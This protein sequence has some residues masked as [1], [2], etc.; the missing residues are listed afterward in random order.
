MQRSRLILQNAASKAAAAKAAGESLAAVRKLQ[1]HKKISLDEKIA[2]Q[3][4]STRRSPPFY[5]PLYHHLDPSLLKPREPGTFSYL[6]HNLQS[7]LSGF[8]SICTSQQSRDE[9]LHLTARNND[10]KINNNHNGDGE[11]NAGI[12]NTF[13]LNQSDMGFMKVMTLY[14]DL[15]SPLYD[16]AN[17]DT[18]T[19]VRQFLDGCS[20]ALEQFHTIQADYLKNLEATLN[21]VDNSENN[22][23]EHNNESNTEEEEKAETGKQ[24]QCKFFD[25]V[26]NDPESTES[27]LASMLSPEGLDRIFFDTA[28]YSFA[29][30]MSGQ[31]MVEGADSTARNHTV[32]AELSSDPKVMHACLLSA[33]VEEIE[34]SVGNQDKTNGEDNDDDH[35]APLEDE[36]LQPFA[37]RKSQT[38]LQLEVLYDLEFL[39]NTDGTR[40]TADDS[41]NRE[42]FKG[43]NVAKFEACIKN[44]PNGDE[45]EW[46]LCSWRPAREFGHL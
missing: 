30:N 16:E 32:L 38:L 1:F 13:V 21:T 33:R 37:D 11:E 18:E 39:T 12:I 43:V 36:S 42:S 22:E 8:Y 17:F 27:A 44:N 23:A 7:S 26:E 29:R 20:F 14:Q 19:E 15:S 9:F 28:I 41:N 34:A 45:L 4:L 40:N 24:F 5:N 31:K 3:I 10:D 2:A 35:D 25:L 6:L 46:R